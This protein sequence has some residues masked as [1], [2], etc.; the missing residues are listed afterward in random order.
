VPA[1]DSGLRELRISTATANQAIQMR[2]KAVD[3]KNVQGRS[4]A[5]G[6][7][8]LTAV[9]NEAKVNRKVEMDDVDPMKSRAAALKVILDETIRAMEADVKILE[10]AFNPAKK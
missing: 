10:A 1:A 8:D 5:Q 9:L 4:V 7:R 6:N 2:V 3:K